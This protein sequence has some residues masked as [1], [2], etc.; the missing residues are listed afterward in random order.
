M[1][2]QRSKEQALEKEEREK[3]KD[4][5]DDLFPL[6]MLSFTLCACSVRSL[7]SVCDSF[8]QFFAL[9][10]LQAKLK[11]S[12]LM[13]AMAQHKL[14]VCTRG[15]MLDLWCELLLVVMCIFHE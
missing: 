1:Q 13:K 15:A 14:E 8:P 9:C 2:K 10:P 12:Q 5:R 4:V 11:Q 6:C 7:L 3:L